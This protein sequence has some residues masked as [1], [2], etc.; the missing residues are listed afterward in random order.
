MPFTLTSSA[1]AH[2]G[3]IP[4]RHTCQGEDVSVPLSWSGVP[5]GTKSLALIIDD[6]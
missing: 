2:H 5:D 1:F 3:E 4:R 6:P